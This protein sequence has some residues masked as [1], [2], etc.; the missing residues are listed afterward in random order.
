MTPPPM[1]TTEAWRGGWLRAW[2]A[3]A[4]SGRGV[5]GSRPFGPGS[6]CRATTG[7]DRAG[8]PG[9]SP[10]C[11]GRAAGTRRTFHGYPR[12]ATLCVVGTG[13]DHSTGHGIDKAVLRSRAVGRRRL[14][15][16]AR[17]PAP[18]ANWQLAVNE[19][20]VFKIHPGRWAVGADLPIR[21]I[22]Q[23]HKVTKN[24]PPTGVRL[25]LH[26]VGTR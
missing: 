11:A 18:L 14:R 1:T 26:T 15:A 16:T 7:R 17:G 21:S 13:A 12:R 20:E 22:A 8:R 4:E 19:E 10:D 24:R 23:R 6:C 25:P 3:L 5:P 2:C 9:E